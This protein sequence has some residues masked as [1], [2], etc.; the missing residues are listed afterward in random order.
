VSRDRGLLVATISSVR[1]P[2]DV[3]ETRWRRRPVLALAVRVVVTTSPLLASV[4]AGIAASR[5]FRPV[6]W[7]AI[8]AWLL[9]VAGVS[10]AVLAVTDLVVRRLLPLQRLLQLCLVFP[11]RAPSRLRLAVTAARRRRPEALAH[12]AAAPGT[13]ADTAARIVAALGAL[14]MHDRR[15]RGH[16]ERVCA[17][18]DLLAE[19]MQ[20]PQGDRDR[21]MWV[22]LIHDIGKLHV[23]PRLLNK[24]E[25]PTVEEWRALQAHPEHGD[26]LVAPMRAWLGSWADAVLQHH[27]RYDGNGYPHG[28]SG[29]QICFGARIIAV[30]DAFE[31]MTA[32]RPYR[33]PVDAQSARAELARH[34]GTQF[35]PE[36]VRHFLALGL[37]KLR[38]SMGWLSWIGQIPFLRDWPKL[39]SAPAA[40]T[41]Q[42]VTATAVA[43]SAGALMFGTVAAA[44][45]AAAHE[46]SLMPFM[47]AP[48]LTSATTAQ[49]PARSPH[50]ARASSPTPLTSSDTEFGRA[51]AT[52][53]RIP[54]SA[55]NMARAPRNTT[56]A[57]ATAAAPGAPPASA[58]PAAPESRPATTGPSASPTPAA[59]DTSCPPGQSKS[60]HDNGQGNAYGR[61]RHYDGCG[62]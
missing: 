37:P 15:T 41:A 40:A 14:A 55:A 35:D 31:V 52:V 9:W 61:H 6:G 11:D 23:T 28:L 5:I 60:P 29:E 7:M 58:P 53:T 10:F 43:S 3:T 30:T 16:S 20:L 21:L 46:S 57:P 27:E 56:T 2:P 4:L 18:T 34:A 48:S 22:A 13:A 24:P 12:S 59:T 32:P 51:S 42:A 36:I 33:R 8:G 47:H 38:T 45:P 62:S 49:P 1:P 26:A 54:A 25:R 17:F 44:P 19:Q 50:P 39:Q